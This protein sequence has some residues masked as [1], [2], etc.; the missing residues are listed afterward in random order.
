MRTMSTSEI[1]EAGFDE[2]FCPN[3]NDEGCEF[4]ESEDE[5]E[6]RTVDKTWMAF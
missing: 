3:C 6:T 4:C 5:V 2:P 1:E